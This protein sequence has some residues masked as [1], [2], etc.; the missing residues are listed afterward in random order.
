MDERFDLRLDNEDSADAEI[1][2][3]LRGIYA[4]PE[5]ASYWDGLEQRVMSYV[6]DRGEAVI[7][8]NWWSDLASWAGP[9][10]AAAA[11]LFVAA[12]L[13]WS[14][15]KDEDLRVSYEAVTDALPYD[16]LPGAVQVVQAPHDGTSQREATF[17]YV[18]SH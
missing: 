7:P 11:L 4:A 12:G 10:L 6:R 16:V 9:G 5:A 18:M 1:T 2:N 15:Q 14:K 8:V 3:A 13:L 17:R